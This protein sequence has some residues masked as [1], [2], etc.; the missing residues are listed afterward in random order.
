[1]AEHLQLRLSV[2]VAKEGAGAEGVVVEGLLTIGR[3]TR[4]INLSSRGGKRAVWAW[5][6]CL[7]GRQALTQ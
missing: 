2:G 4:E 6:A 3:D 7:R 1:M 5:A